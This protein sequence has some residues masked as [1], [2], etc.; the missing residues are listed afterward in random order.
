MS[1]FAV[2]QSAAW[3]DFC[4]LVRCCDTC[5]S[6]LALWKKVSKEVDVDNYI[7]TTEL[8]QH[9]LERVKSGGSVPTYGLA[10]SI[11]KLSKLLK[12]Y[13]KELKSIGDRLASYLSSSRKRRSIAQH[14]ARLHVQLRAMIE[15]SGVEMQRSTLTTAETAASAR[16]APL[17]QLV[18]QRTRARLTAADGFRFWQKYF[19]ELEMELVPFESLLS[20]YQKELGVALDSSDAALLQRTSFLIHPIVE[21]FNLPPP[22]PCLDI[23]DRDMIGAVT[24]SDFNNFLKLFGNIAE[25]LTNAKTLYSQRWFHDF[26]SVDEVMRLLADQPVGTFLVRYSRSL[27]GSFVLDYVPSPG[28]LKTLIIKSC[29]SSGVEFADDDGHAHM[30]PSIS[31]LVSTQKGQYQTRSVSVVVASTCSNN[32]KLADILK[33]P[34]MLDFLNKTWFCGSVSSDEAEKMLARL[35]VGTFLARFAEMGRFAFY[36]SY[37][38]RDEKTHERSIRHASVMKVPSGY[39]LDLNPVIQL[40]PRARDDSAA[41]A[42][43]V[44]KNSR[45]KSVST[46]IKPACS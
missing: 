4:I 6:I 14:N 37:V 20:A 22:P 3:S 42:K 32:C 27:P 39:L 28:Q 17:P 30:Y 33:F 7:S 24:P 21:H 31:N 11:K 16:T 40:T 15:A 5:V 43:G 41:P 44:L 26:L 8:A 10:E 9:L 36:V 45:E 23:L 29:G 1:T 38:H 19:A 12:E 25:A 2:N 18:T 35:P 13:E 34:L 46:P